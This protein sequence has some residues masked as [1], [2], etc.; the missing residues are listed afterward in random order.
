MRKHPL[1]GP[2]VAYQDVD[3]RI[4]KDR[5]EALNNTL[6][7][8]NVDETVMHDRNPTLGLLLYRLAVLRCRRNQV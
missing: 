2:L 4:R 3:W 1:G 8:A 6:C 7:P 5:M